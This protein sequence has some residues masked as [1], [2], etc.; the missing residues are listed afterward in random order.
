MSGEVNNSEISIYPNPVE[1]ALNI[2]SESEIK[3]IV[4]FDM[5]GKVVYRDAK[6]IGTQLQIDVAGLTHGFY[7]I[8]IIREGNITTKQFIKK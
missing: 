5:L 2:K 3:E 7:L 8:S 6:I 4:I 1:S